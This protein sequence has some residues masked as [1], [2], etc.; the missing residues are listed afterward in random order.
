MIQEINNGFNGE[1]I[2]GDFFINNNAYKSPEIF[3]EGKYGTKLD[4]YSLGVIAL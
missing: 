3:K 4:I 1:Y 2:Y